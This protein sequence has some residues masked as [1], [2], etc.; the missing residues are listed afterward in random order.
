LLLLVPVA[1]EQEQR[2]AIV[3][4]CVGKNGSKKKS[5]RIARRSG[6]KSRLTPEK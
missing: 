3:V 6:E 2:P 5:E 1:K 4:A